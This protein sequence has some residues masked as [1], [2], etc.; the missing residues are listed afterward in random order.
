MLLS[1]NTYYP[2]DDNLREIISTGRMLFRP[3][4][5]ISVRDCVEA[6]RMVGENESARKGMFDAAVTPYIVEPMNCFNIPEVDHVTFMSSAQIS[7]TEILK[8]IIFYIIEEDP[9]P[10]LIV[11]PTDGDARDFSNEKLEPMIENN[12]CL[13]EKVSPQKSNSKDNKT[14][15]KKFM[16]GFLAITGGR[17][18]QDLARRSIKY[19]FLDDRDRITTAGYEG[20]AGELAWQRTESYA[21]LGRKRFEFS[22]PTIEGESA[23]KASYLQSDRREYYVPCPHCGYMQTLKFENLIWDKDTD[24]MGKTIKHY[25]DTVKYKCENPECGKLVDEKDKYDVL[26]MGKWIPGNPDVRDHRGYSINRLYSTFSSWNEIVKYFLECKDD[27]TKLQVF[28]NTVLGKTWKRDESEDVDTTGLMKR[29]EHYLTDK[30]DYRIPN[31][32]LVLVLAADT[33]PDRLEY[34]VLGFG[35]GGEMYLVEYGKLYGDADQDEVYNALELIQRKKWKREDGI[36]LGIY[37]RPGFDFPV[38]VDSGGRNTTTVY[39][40]CRKRY[41]M[42]WMAVKGVGGTEKPIL[43]NVTKVG[44]LK[45]TLLQNVGIDAAKTL[46]H[47][48]LRKN[49]SPAKIHFTSAYANQEYFQQLTN[50][51]LVREYNK[52]NQTVYVWKKKSQHARNEVLDTAVY[53]I[54]AFMKLNA[55]MIAIKRRLDEKAA[56]IK[57][58]A[59]TLPTETA[60]HKEVRVR[61]L[62]RRT[63]PRRRA[64]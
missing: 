48:M 21:L 47:K 27:R 40:Q 50:E 2:Y 7:K 12:A 22:T 11:Y 57:S 14:L 5:R 1:E 37:N 15:Y 61:K 24:L 56:L 32:V 63:S 52:K 49:E 25:P 41:S 38:V 19:V 23:I 44:P 58:P 51:H 8:S 18:P 34:Q 42:G 59:D 9:S 54:A 43:L 26:L 46:I 17:V 62:R 3:R 4:L 39:K 55:N 13:R 28:Y 36:E 60:A 53:G 35:L 31:E 6:R 16:G 30:N 45:D 10:C 29:C 33:Q 64:I 20:D